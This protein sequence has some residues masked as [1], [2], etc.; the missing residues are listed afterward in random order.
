MLDFPSTLLLCPFFR[1]FDAH[2]LNLALCILL[3]ETRQLAE[4]IILRVL[5]F[6]ITGK[7]LSRIEGE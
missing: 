2:I 5:S 1:K 7:I 4:A 6:R 3:A